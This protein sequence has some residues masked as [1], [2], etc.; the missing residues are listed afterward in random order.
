[1]F[2]SLGR[3]IRAVMLAC[4]GSLIA[5]ASAGAVVG[6]TTVGTSVDTNPMGRAQDYR[7][8]ATATE[9]VNRLSVYLDGSNTATAVHLGLFANGSDGTAGSRLGRCAIT[10][11]VA[12]AWNRCAIVPVNVTSGGT[13]WLAVV[14]P[15]GSSGT[16]AFR[17]R[18]AAGRT[19][20]SASGSLGGIPAAWVNG[21]DRGAETASVYADRLVKAAAYTPTGVTAAATGTSVALNWN[22]SPDPNFA[23]FAV[24]RSTQANPDAGTWTRLAPNYTISAATDSGLAAGTYYYYVRQVD[25]AGTASGRSAVVSATVGAFPSPGGCASSVA[26]VPGG[27][28]RFGGCWPGDANTGVPAGTALSAYTGPCTITAANTV[29]EAKTVDCVL[30]IAAANVQIRNTRINGSVWI[31]DPAKPYSFTITDSEIDAGPVDA[32][33]NDGRSAIGKSH[34]VATRVETHG[35]IRGVW[36]EFACTVQDSWIHGQARDSGGHAHE[37]AV[38]MGDG[39]TIRHNTLLCDA[40]DV[41][42]DAGCSADLTGYGDF[43]PIRNNTIDKNLF[44]ATPGGT[45]AYGGSSG[46]DGS[47]P[48]G[49]QAANIS[50]SDNVFQRRNSVQASG[51]CGYWF[52]VTDFDATRPGNRWT[53]NTWDDGTP[54]IPG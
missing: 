27:R 54:V 22:D 29:I 39:S 24:R 17:N 25:K 43:A 49:N 44:M 34:F 10:A 41:A 42:P 38:R 7:V 21:E 36:C 16:F 26:N 8:T 40:P 5:C 47:K 46:K 28:D 9:P 45:C 35:G 15:A 48:Y 11:P 3:M 32:T 6:S 33:H 2:R 37:S 18:T 13:Y 23:Y 52:A 31:E 14:H 19:F 30:T 51:R 53:N 1:M 50:F 12:N 4:A 20:A